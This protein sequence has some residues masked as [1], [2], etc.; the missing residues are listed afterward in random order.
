MKKGEKE[1]II[2]YE[3]KPNNIVAC[4]VFLA[5]F[6]YLFSLV[7]MKYPEINS[8]LELA[9]NFSF[10]LIMYLIGWVGSITILGY[11]I[12]SFFNEM[13]KSMEYTDE[14]RLWNR[15]KTLI[16]EKIIEIKELIPPREPK[17]EDFRIKYKTIFDGRKSK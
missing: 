2:K 3:Q 7:F 13:L 15:E 10:M 17:K 16:G 6:G 14:G 12:V 1:Y 11:F 9:E 5:V 8:S 4:I